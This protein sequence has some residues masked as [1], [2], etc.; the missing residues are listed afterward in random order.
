VPRRQ[1]PQESTRDASTERRQ[2][3]REGEHSTNWETIA[4]QRVARRVKSLSD[5]AESSV[6][7]S[8]DHGWEDAA[9]LTLRRRIRDLE[10]K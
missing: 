3:P 4:L 2:Q 5:D 8:H 1:K 6:D 10:S 7:P 9:L